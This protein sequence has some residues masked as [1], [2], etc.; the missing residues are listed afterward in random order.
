MM[1]FFLEKFARR[2]EAKGVT[3]YEDELHNLSPAAL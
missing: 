3:S 2:I 1:I